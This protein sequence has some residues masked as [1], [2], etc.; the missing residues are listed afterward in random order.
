MILGRL[1]LY[2][3]QAV[4]AGVPRSVIDFMSEPGTARAL[5]ILAIATELLLSVGLWPRRTRAF[6]LWWGVCF[7]LTI[8]A[9]SSVEGFTW[10]TLAMY[11]L[12]ATPDVR[13]RSLVHDATFPRTLLRALSALDWLARFKLQP[14][15]P[16]DPDRGIVVVDRDGA[17]FSGP[18]AIT[19]LARGIPLLFPLWIPLALV[20][21]LGARL[22]R[23][24]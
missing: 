6:A 2:G 4:R 10:L 16:G 24:R 14:R 8:E 18:R 13:A 15:L 7:H 1:S 19:A 20:A 17:R 3:W 12:F 22:S 5:A 23:D 21:I 9:T 11:A